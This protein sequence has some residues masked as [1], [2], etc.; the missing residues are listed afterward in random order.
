[1]LAAKLEVAITPL[2]DKGNRLDIKESGIKLAAKEEDANDQGILKEGALTRVL[3]LKKPEEL[4][5]SPALTLPV[6]LKLKILSLTRLAA[7]ELP[8]IKLEIKGKKLEELSKK[9]GKALNKDN[10]EVKL[11]IA[12]EDKDRAESRLLAL[13]RLNAGP[14]LL[15]APPKE[16]SEG[17]RIDKP[18][19]RLEDINRLLTLLTATLLL[20]KPKLNAAKEGKAKE[21][22]KLD[23]A[24]GKEELLNPRL[25]KA[26]KLL[27]IPLLKGKEAESELKAPK[28]GRLE[29]KS[30]VELKELLKPN[31]EESDKGSK[32]ELDKAAKE[33]GADKEGNKLAGMLLK[34]GNN[35]LL[36]VK[37]DPG[38]VK[39]DNKAAEGNSKEGGI[40][41]LKAKAKG[42]K[43]DKAA[44]ELK[45]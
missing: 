25:V 38:R 8:T 42:T 10:T 37:R 2:K 4:A 9:A 34:A 12:E 15:R 36:E 11:T 18:I 30:T 28:E 24:K 14:K 33:E 17:I 41:L 22:N 40:E 19:I 7:V 6:T 45:L 44:L 21:D 3:K 20:A 43:E 5:R 13:N 39:E 27:K 1:M 35:T 16:E 23:K 31:S 29:D 26:A 32:T